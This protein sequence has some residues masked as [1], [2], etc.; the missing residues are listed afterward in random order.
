M[1]KQQLI[2]LSLTILCFCAFL[3]WSFAEEKSEAGKT[4]FLNNKCNMC[5]SIESE[6]IEKTT[7]GY[8]KSKEKNVPPDLTKIGQKHNAEWISGYITKKETLDDKKHAKAF[9]GTNE[10][11]EAIANWLASLK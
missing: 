2:I 6:K 8:Q 5:H 3:S 9:R 7:G 1:K 4:A 10:E 11:L